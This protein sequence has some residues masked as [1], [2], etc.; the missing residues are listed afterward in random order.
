PAHAERAEKAQR[1]ERVCIGRVRTALL[2]VG[3]YSLFSGLIAFAPD[4]H[5]FATLRFFGALGMG[6]TWTAG[7]AL[8]AET[9][10]PGRR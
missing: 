2:C 8:I 7:A 6:G 1:G 10:H 9:W 3:I 5:A 4:A